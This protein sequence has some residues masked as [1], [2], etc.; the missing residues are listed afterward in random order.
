FDPVEGFSR[1][2]DHKDRFRIARGL[3]DRYR[4]RKITALYIGG[5]CPPKEVLRPMCRPTPASGPPA[6]EDVLC[7]SADDLV[8]TPAAVYLLVDRSSAMR[9]ELPKL[10]EAIDLA[11][12]AQFVRNTKVALHLLPAT[13]SACAALPSPFGTLAGPEAVPFAPPEQ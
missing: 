2:P 8:P 9:D 10:R 13:A 11:L 6:P 1:V 12:Q 5:N 7:T 4:A 3:C